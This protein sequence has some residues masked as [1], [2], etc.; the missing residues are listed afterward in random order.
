[1]H[2]R[3][4]QLPLQTDA[5]FARLAS[6]PWEETLLHAL[7]WSAPQVKSQ[8]LLQEELSTKQMDVLCVSQAHF[9]PVDQLHHAQLAIV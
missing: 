4:A 5:Q 9:L 1:L 6:S 2:P 8:R 3:L 7:T